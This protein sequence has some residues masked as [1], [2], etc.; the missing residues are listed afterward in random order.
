MNDT[1][2]FQPEARSILLSRVLIG[3]FAL[4]V[5]FLDVVSIALCM[6]KNLFLM[7]VL[8][9]QTEV[10]LLCICVFLG[11]VPAYILLVDMNRL[12][13]NLR[14]GDVFTA[15]NVH[16]LKTV[17][18]CCFAAGLICFGFSVRFP[19]LFAITLAAGF[20][21]LIVRIVKNVFQ[22]AIS[23]KDELDFTI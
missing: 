11:S 13:C 10:Y 19:A 12:L 6:G 8:F 3:V 23:M 21:G 16:L 14:Q 1:A 20:V 17:S 22:Q 2:R 4:A 18:Y 9:S 5:L 15:Q 7:K